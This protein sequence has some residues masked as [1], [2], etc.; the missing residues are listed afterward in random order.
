MLY[1]FST[2]KIS[3]VFGMESQN[4]LS[5]LNNLIEPKFS[6]FRSIKEGKIK[7]L[8]TNN[9][10][11]VDNLTT[12]NNNEEFNNQFIDNTVIEIPNVDINETSN[13]KPIFL[14]HKRN[15]DIED[16]TKYCIKHNKF[17]KDNVVKKIFV[18]YSKC[19]RNYLNNIIT[20]INESLD[21]DKKIKK[22]SQFNS[23]SRAT[24]Y[25]LRILGN[26]PL[27]YYIA[28]SVGTTPNDDNI[29]IIE[30]CIKNDSICK[31]ICDVFKM[32]G[33][34]FFDIFKNSKFCKNKLE[35]IKNEDI[36]YHDIF[37]KTINNFFKI[38]NE[39]YK[40]EYRN[41]DKEHFL[42][43]NFNETIEHYI[44]INKL[45]INNETK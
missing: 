44:N 18:L 41:K 24:F 29:K 14:V 5:T 3:T 37:Q 36:E 13:K 23:A 45:N 12:I 26:S 38:L 42:C 33:C 35:K 43:T 22:F 21:K 40:T 7:H 4:N 9:Y 2:V 20:S 30:N 28:T 16:N 1:S 39:C 8:G 25:D 31:D 34:E 32:K 27:I 11:F 10:I 15:H 6:V 19:L 17:S